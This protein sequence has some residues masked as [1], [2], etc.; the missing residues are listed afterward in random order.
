MRFDAAPLATAWLPRGHPHVPHVGAAVLVALFSAACYASSAVL[1]ERQAARN[2]GAGATTLVRRLVRQ[3]LWWL[4]IAATLTGAGL[5]VVAL[6]LGPL[7]VVQPVAVT[8][9]VLALPLGAAVVGRR[10]RPR[11]WGA[12][13]AVVA[14]LTPLVLAAPRHAHLAHLPPALIA[15]AAACVTA[16]V[17]GLLALAVRLPRP[18][19]SVARAAAAATAFATASAM[20]RTALTGAGSPSLALPLTACFAVGGF[21]VAQL[22]YR[23]GGLGGPLA[24]LTL[25]EP[26]VAGVLGVAV[27]GERLDATPVLVL[28]GSAGL[29][30]TALGV[31][32]LTRPQADRPQ[33]R[34]RRRG[35]CARDE[36]S[37]GEVPAPI[38]LADADAAAHHEAPRPRAPEPARPAAAAARSA[39]AAPH[40]DAG[41][42]SRR[43]RQDHAPGRMGGLHRAT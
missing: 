31:R 16:L 29:V 6:A 34:S 41:L 18:A 5:H 28:L 9:L 36:Q 27:L 1:Q 17:L 12:A 13:A 43:L 22:A 40:A 35:S 2:R 37:P 19:A 25:V 42:G 33:P 11:E 30:S 10:V 21:V 3:P 15:T 4:A 32:A 26:L 20:A 38:P 7:T 24:T 39:G 8:T 23:D 14:G